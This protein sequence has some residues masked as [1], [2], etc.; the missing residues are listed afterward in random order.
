MQPKI[1]H[2]QSE[3][4]IKAPQVELFAYLDDQTRLAAHMKKRS[5]MM[6][7]GRM[8]YEFDAAKGRAVGSVIRMGGSFLGISLSVAE[9]VTERTPPARKL[10]EPRGPQRML[11][12]DSDV[13]G[14][15]TRL[16]GEGT[17]V[18]V[19]IDYQLPPGLP[20]RWLGLLFAPLYARW[21][22]SRMVKD[23]TRHFGSVAEPG[24]AA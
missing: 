4:I 18:R 11:V 1:Y 17:G 6:L 5:M 22:V 3:A 10:W 7:G 23:V 12:I 24:V 13:M 2:D 20:G 15:E 21:C 14:F 16:I 19:F 9:I 8:T